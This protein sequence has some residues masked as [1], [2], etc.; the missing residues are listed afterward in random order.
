M[1]QFALP[2]SICINLYTCIFQYS[3]TGT[4]LLSIMAVRCGADSITA[5]EAFKPMA[6]CCLKILA[7]NGVADKITVIPKRSTDIT[8]GADGDMKEKAN[9]LVTEVFDTE[10]IGEGTYLHFNDCCSKYF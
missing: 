3:G 9:I 5:C 2:S 6:E 8:V 1:R 4:G 10:L 7:K